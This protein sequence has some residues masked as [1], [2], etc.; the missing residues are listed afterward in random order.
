[1]SSDP[2]KGMETIKHEGAGENTAQPNSEAKMSPRPKHGVRFWG[3][4]V[5]LCLLAFISALDVAIITTA[6]PTI[7]AEVGGARQYVWIA[8]SFVAASCVLQ[9]LFGQLADAFGRR[10]P[11]VAAVSLFAL[12]SAL[13]GAAQSVAMLLAGRTIQGAGAGGMYVLLDIVCCDL[14]PLRERGKYLGLLFSWSGVAAAIGPPVGGALAASNWRWI[15]YL[16][17]PFCGLSF[18]GLLLFM[19]VGT[20]NQLDYVGNLI[21]IPST[22]SLLIGL[23]EGGVE[24]PWSSWRI[25]V[26]LASVPSVPPRL[27]G[28]RTSATAL[29]L[30]FTSSVLVQAISYFFP[31]Y[32]QAVQGTTVQESG[33]FFLPFA[34]GSLVFAILGGILLS[35]LALA[36][37]LFTRL[38]AVTPKVAWVLFQLVNS[39]GAGLVM[40]TL[41]PAVMAPLPETDVAAAAATYSLVRTFGYIWGVVMPGVIF[42]A[43]FDK[44]LDHISNESLRSQLQGGAAYS[45]ASQAHALYNTPN[46]VVWGQVLDVYTQSLRRD[47]ELRKQLDTDYGLEENKEAVVPSTEEDESKKSKEVSARA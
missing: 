28:N 12:G 29:L 26:F 3:I 46:P 44:N 33:T 14:V 23:V 5:S 43:V 7:T 21:F 16:N 38:D 40:S 39:A 47:V 45:F 42:N 17:L 2:R 13:G 30:T 32:L 41:L 24:R 31:V 6:L 18:A 11:L 9:P 36:F 1:M 27:F 15:F 20:G 22:V 34:M 35:T 37:G 4:F 19:S 10:G 8:N 25:I